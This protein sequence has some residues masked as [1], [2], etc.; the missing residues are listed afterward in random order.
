M[1]FNEA[2]NELADKE[3]ILPR[4]HDKW[5]HEEDSLE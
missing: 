1:D 5:I 3:I 4:A 2:W